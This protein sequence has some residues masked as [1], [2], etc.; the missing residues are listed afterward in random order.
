M[1]DR[2][3]WATLYIVCHIM[4]LQSLLLITKLL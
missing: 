1:P 3:I 2:Q 4:E